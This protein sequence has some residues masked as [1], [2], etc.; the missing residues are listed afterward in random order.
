[1]VTRREILGKAV[2]DCMKELY[3]QAQPSVT[4]EEFMQQNVEYVKKEK[5]WEAM[6]RD[7]RPGINEYCGPKPFEFYYLPKDVLKEI[8]ASY[9]DAYKIDNQQELLDTIDIL[10]QY[11][12][13][14]IV[15]KYI[16]GKGKPGDEYWEPGHRGYEHPDNLEKEL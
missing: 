13:E 5:E 1:M 12:D 4:W 6:D 2:V 16:E 11:C 8:V 9:V 7:T 3:E 10:K 15:D 14:P